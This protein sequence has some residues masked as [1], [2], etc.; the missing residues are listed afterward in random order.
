MHLYVLI[1]ILT[2]LRPPP[3]IYESCQILDNDKTSEPGHQIIYDGNNANLCATQDGKKVVNN[4]T[5]F[6][7]TKAVGE[8]L[9]Y[10]IRREA[11][12]QE[13]EVIGKNNG[14][15]CQKE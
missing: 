14:I 9:W 2:I 4:V 7:W 13:T 10:E 8:I 11:I 5:I 1:R 15:V 6:S 12:F 3:N